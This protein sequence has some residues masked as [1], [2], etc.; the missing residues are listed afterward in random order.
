MLHPTLTSIKDVIKFRHPKNRIL[1]LITLI[2]ISFSIESYPVTDTTKGDTRLI[3]KGK[4]GT[5]EISSQNQKKDKH[6]SYINDSDN[7]DGCNFFGSAIGEFLRFIFVEPIKA[8]FNRDEIV[9][10]FS[11]KKFKVGFGGSIL[12]FS[13]YPKASF[14]YSI[15][16]NG[17]ILFIPNEFISIRE[18]LGIHL[19]PLGGF[20]SDFERDVYANGSSIGVEKDKGDFYYNFS[21]PLNTEI[22]VRP[23]GANGS[24]FFLIGGGP[25]YVYEKFT[26]IR[27]Y[28][29]QNS[30]DSITISDGN[31]IPTLS[32]GIGR[33]IEIEIGGPFSSFEIR[34]SLGINPNRKKISLPG[35]NSKYVH[36]FT[37]IQYQI[38]F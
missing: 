23:A 1:W 28:S 33:L 32:F 11:E 5:E 12:D 9:N 30:K 26:G 2:I 15:K 18:H 19:S 36:G 8:I 31:W 35:E 3:P 27:E 29:Y 14:S 7:D 17:D 20:L 22:M 10:N 21:F 6:N 16:F 34:Y 24:L 4:E 25:R 37:L 38:F 13:L